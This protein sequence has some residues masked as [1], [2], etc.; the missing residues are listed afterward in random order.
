MT[1]NSKNLMPG[2]KNIFEP[3]AIFGSSRTLSCRLLTL[4]SIRFSLIHI[5]AMTNSLTLSSFLF[6]ARVAINRKKETVFAGAFVTV[7]RKVGN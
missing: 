1:I 4:F 3:A 5:E 7:E 2:A 6:A